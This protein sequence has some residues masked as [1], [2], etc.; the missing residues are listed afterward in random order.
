MFSSTF[1]S[2]AGQNILENGKPIGYCI[3]ELDD[4][5]IVRPESKCIYTSFRPERAE[6]ISPGQRPG[7]DVQH[8]YSR[9]V[10]ARQLALLVISVPL[11]LQGG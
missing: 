10:R 4:L 2:I 9:P 1:K 6:H 8:G 11:P 3:M 7:N 5:A